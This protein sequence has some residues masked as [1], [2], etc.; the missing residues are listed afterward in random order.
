[1]DNL[2]LGGRVALV[3]GGANGI[4]AGVTR[5]LASLGARLVIADL[6]QD[7]GE[8]IAKEVD[9]VFV[10]C[11]VR[12]PA[13]SEAAVAAA[14]ERFGGLDLVHLNA[15]VESLMGLGDDFDVTRYRQV[16]GVNLDGVVFGVH[17]ALPALRARGGGTIVVTASMAGVVAMPLD[18]LYSAN[19]HAVVGLV[20]SLGEALAPEGIKVQAICPSYAETSLIDTFRSLL[21]DA[22]FPI[23]DVGTVADALV[24]AIA[25]DGS[26][27][28]WYV[29]PGRA[30][31]PFRFRR[32]P[33]P[34]TA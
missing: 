4:G 17:A 5:R 10:R 33:G 3:T 11:D 29:V 32:A 2:D 19:K 31:E 25:S 18:P 13:D 12:D 15:G 8:M 14:V 20:R 30:S 6:D 22:G 23:L 1:M 21:E 28:C 34:R 27:E 9:G 24:Q 7:A 26:G 16:M